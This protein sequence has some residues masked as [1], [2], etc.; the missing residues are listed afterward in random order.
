MSAPKTGSTM[1]AASA[2]LAAA[3]D[4]E[5]LLGERVASAGQELAR[6][7]A[8]GIDEE[9]RARSAALIHSTIHA[10]EIALRAVEPALNI[11][12]PGR[13]GAAFVSAGLLARSGLAA[14]ALLRA[15]EHRLAAALVRVAGEIEGPGAHRLDPI[16]GEFAAESFAVRAAESA[17]LDRTGDPLLPLHD[18]AAEDRHAL[19]WQ[20]AACLGAQALAEGAEEEALHRAAAAAVA[21]ALAGVDEGEGIAPAALRLAHR[22]EEAGQVDDALLAGTLAGGRIASLAAMLAVKT[23]VGFD[24]ARAMLTDA[25]RC[26]V[27][28]RACAVER[29]IAA[30]M[31]L[32]LALGLDRGFGP[33]PAANAAI[34]I[35]GFETLPIAEARTEVRRARLEPLYREALAALGQGAC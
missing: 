33:D 26:A 24:D 14:A 23:G 25:A 18:L 12:T 3:Q 32:T 6:P 5:L 13:L 22:L 21:R 10:A 29:D 31:I 16:G 27:L 30:A 8:F 35:D 15:E 34:L 20:V 9:M 17:R 28:L 4:A 1:P 11:G 2:L 7:P 19:F